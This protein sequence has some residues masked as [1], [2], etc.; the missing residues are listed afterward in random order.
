MAE[1]KG[2]IGE[3]I[4]VVFF[5]LIV[6]KHYF[7]MMSQSQAHWI[8]VSIVYWTGVGAIGFA[9]WY[10]FRLFERPVL[11]PKQR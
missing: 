1:S 4:G 11:K 10:A 3:G 2:G 6:L 9:L 5:T 7:E 8:R